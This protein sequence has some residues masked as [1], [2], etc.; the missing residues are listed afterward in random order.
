M[1][2]M[3]LY[4]AL[5]LLLV[6]FSNNVVYSYLYIS[7]YLQYLHISISVYFIVVCIRFFFLLGDGIDRCCDLMHRQN[8][9]N[10]IQESHVVAEIAQ[11]T[12][13]GDSDAIELGIV[14]EGGNGQIET[15]RV[16]RA[17][18]QEQLHHS[19]SES[20]FSQL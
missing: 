1:Q 5:L 4:I 17:R 3:N 20:H 11:T 19:L 12:N 9:L 6:N 15:L 13:S 8:I 18:V 7:L 14:D 16:A 2:T 10:Q